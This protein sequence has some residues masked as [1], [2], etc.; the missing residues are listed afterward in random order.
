MAPNLKKVPKKKTL[1]AIRNLF[2]DPQ[3][4]CQ[5]MINHRLQI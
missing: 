1:I 3:K 4:A 5:L 2:R